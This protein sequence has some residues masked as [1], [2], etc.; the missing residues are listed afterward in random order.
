SGYLTVSSGSTS[1]ISS[2]G[3]A[4][5]PNFT[6]GE[7]VWRPYHWVFWRGTVSSQ[8]PASV[9][10]TAFPSTSGGGTEAPQA[11]YGFFFQN[12]PNACTSLGEWA[13]NSSTHK[14]TM[15]FGATGP[16]SYQ[17]QAT[18]IQDL[19]VLGGQSF[20]IFND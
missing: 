18:T 4:G 9:S 7:V 8:S 13:Y 16:G 5:I 19:V 12:H 2:S 3:L 11:N 17:V 20:I 1:S 15:Y 6:G 14:L 10:F